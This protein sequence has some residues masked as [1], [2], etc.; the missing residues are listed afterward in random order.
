MIG[1]KSQ[2][3]EEP[4]KRRKS[5]ALGATVA[6]LLTLLLALSTGTAAA[7]TDIAGCT[8][9][10]SPGS[11]EV[12][13][14]VDKSL[15]GYCFTV[16]GDDVV[17]DGNGN[18][19]NATTTDPSGAITVSN[20]GGTVTNVSISNL[21]ITNFETG[22]SVD[23]AE[24]VE[25]V[26]VGTV[27][28]GTSVSVED[29][30][31]VTVE[32]STVT[33]A[34]VGVDVESSNDVTVRKSSLSSTPFELPDFD[35]PID[36]PPFDDP[37]DPPGVLS[38]DGSSVE[39]QSS[40]DT[41]IG[42]RLNETQ[43]VVVENN[44]VS[45]FREQGVLVSV[46]TPSTGSNEIID[47]QVINN[48]Q[49]VVVS[50]TADTTSP[51][52][53][54]DNEVTANG[55]GIGIAGFTVAPT[56]RNEI[57]GNELTDNQNGISVLSQEED[58]IDNKVTNS[59]EVGIRV[60][61]ENVDTSENTVTESGIA[62]IQAQGGSLNILTDNIVEDNGEAGIRVGG[63][64]FD[65]D[66]ITLVNNTATGNQTYGIWINGTDDNELRENE[67]NG[68]NVSGI[69]L[70]G[71]SDNNE[72][73]D[74]TANDN[75][76]MTSLTSY[77]I[78]L[79]DGSNDNKIIDNEAFDNEVGGGSA[80]PS[81]GI[82]LGGSRPTTPIEPVENNTVEENTVGSSMSGNQRYGIWVAGANRNKLR[83]N[84]AENNNRSGIYLGGVSGTV[85][86]KNNTIVNNTARESEY[87]ILLSNAFDNDV[88]ESLVENNDKG[89]AVE[90][91]L[92]PLSEGI[93]TEYVRQTGNTFTDDVS[94]NNDW[95]FVVDSLDI[96]LVS[97]SATSSG[98]PVTNLSIGTSTLPETTLSFNADDVR[99]RSVDSP[100]PDPDALENIG[101][102]F[103][104]DK[105]S[106]DAFL[107]VSL[108][109]EDGDVA[110]VNES[111]LELLRF[112]GG[113]DEWLPIGSSVDTTENSVSTNI[114]TFSDFGAFGEEESPDDGG[115]GTGNVTIEAPDE[116]KPDGE[117]E[118]DVNMT[119]SSVGEV[120]AESSDFG[121]ELSVVDADG[122]ST[123]EQTD[124]SVEFIDPSGST[125]NYTLKV[126]VTGSSDGETGTIT[127]A[128]G[129][130]IGDPGADDEKT[131]QFTVKEGVS[132]VSISSPDTVPSD[133][134]F[135][136]DVNMTNS[137][138][139]EVAAE[140]SDFG[141]EL[142]VIDDDGDSI[143]EQTDTSVEF[144][145]VDGEDSNYTLKV[146]VTGGSEGDTGTITAATGGSIGDP[147]VDDEV[148]ETF[149]ISA[150]LESPIEDVSDELWTA[151]TSQDGDAGN[152]SLSDL[153]DA[154][155]AYR[156]NPSD[157]D[158]DGVTIRLSDLGDLI[159]YYRNEVV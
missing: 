109:Y 8:N 17:I 84:V 79:E 126:N 28:T 115:P 140:S 56:P 133:G 82:Y 92:I 52:Q 155:Q 123:G 99:L 117:F 112:D 26:N 95:D 129:G 3:A 71:E 146:N 39:T 34:D 152:L 142:S 51:N 38:K 15:T 96:G 93:E 16:T 54:L 30:E 60:I 25:L 106:V 103:E 147:G 57:S 94:R 35:D 137:S 113:P 63:T 43:G 110:G 4:K 1:K 44:T 66:N 141:V 5:L 37:F 48:S 11:Y 81:A 139:G 89:I 23:D 50:M 20:V 75:G 7:Q 138:V 72:I 78:W 42:I 156:A 114:T 97:T 29:S 10:N 108:S 19:I 6:L 36:D 70:N 45:D 144:I 73:E 158:I 104:A 119:N 18:T 24:D 33:D 127:A 55:L 145:D 76:Q 74:N 131:E 124:T 88:S 49:G 132:E 157:A 68:N 134:E 105:L 116:V 46:K 150:V 87:G 65:V 13:G 32:G 31:D 159:Q 154:I 107:N 12:T 120:A 143:G 9:V 148:T 91:T 151:V 58:I 27:S 53:V 2:N 121:V 14:D 47:N 111:T 69:Y 100:E 83:G 136:F 153:G 128:T 59:T 86:T 125:S 41:E 21:T 64:S 122:D 22:V 67:A 90:Q 98:F 130:N 101:R 40:H 77:G 85:E 149:E 135:E 61:G 118:F 62:G 80:G 102:Y